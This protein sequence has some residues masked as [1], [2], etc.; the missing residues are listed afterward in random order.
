MA[1]GRKT[2][3]FCQECGYES[4]KW[5]G[6]C[7]GCRQWNTFVKRRCRRLP[8]DRKGA[9]GGS[10]RIPDPVPLSQVAVTEEERCI[11][12]SVSWTGCWAAVLWEVP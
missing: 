12:E 2:V 1:K 7:P 10:H 9:G 11:Q 5:L 4:S 8:R 3:F 6:Q